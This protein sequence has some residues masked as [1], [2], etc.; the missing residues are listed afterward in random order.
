MRCVLAGLI[1]GA[2]ALTTVGAQR[3]SAPS[4]SDDSLIPA[5][6]IRLL[7]V[8]DETS[9]EPL[10]GVRVLAINSG[11]SSLTTRTGTVTLVYLPPGLNAVRLQKVG[12]EPQ[13]MSVSIGPAD[14]TPVTVLMHRV[15]ELPKVTTTAPETKYISPALRGFEERR[16]MALSGYF[17]GDS[18]LRAEE[19]RALGDVLKAHAP[20]V[21]IYNGKANANWLVQSPRCMMG[22]PPQVYIDGVAISAPLAPPPGTS[23]V[24]PS[25]RGF[26]GSAAAQAK[27]ASMPFDL[28]L[29]KVMD[30]AG[31]EWYPDN[32]QAPI[33]FAHTSGRCGA[34][35]LWT[36]ER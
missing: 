1:L 4:P 23:P 17:I 27:D 33:E 11:L 22:G 34:L 7:G 19:N 32:D 9:S 2:G 36:R 16:K 15:T 5:Y 28:S 8:Y 31:V 10:A 6:R 29:F 30:Y 14:T 26:G 13:T 20:S 18:V 3:G 25:T 24:K 21:I 12:Y 35:M